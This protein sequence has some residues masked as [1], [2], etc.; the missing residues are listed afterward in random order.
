MIEFLFLLVEILAIVYLIHNIVGVSVKVDVYLIM[1]LAIGLG[2]TIAIINDLIWDK[3]VCIVYGLCGLYVVVELKKKN[4]GCNMYLWCGI[5][6]GYSFADS[7]VLANGV[8][9]LFGAL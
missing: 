9:L 2:I 8:A 1:L 3:G 7:F 4:G 5:V 6:S